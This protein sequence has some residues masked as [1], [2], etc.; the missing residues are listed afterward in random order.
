MISS[1]IPWVTHD[2]IW[3][4]REPVDPGLRVQVE[5]R[6]LQWGEIIAVQPG[7]WDWEQDDV[8]ITVRLDSGEVVSTTATMCR[9][10]YKPTAAD[11]ADRMIFPLLLDGLENDI[12]VGTPMFFYDEEE[13]EYQQGRVVGRHLEKQ[14]I[15][16][17][18]DHYYTV[19]EFFIETGRYAGLY[20]EDATTYVYRITRKYAHLDE[21]LKVHGVW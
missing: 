6:Q 9:Y 2:F 21:R 12:P 19:I 1:F 13:D 5:D 20:W 10:Q 7:L 11:L 8:P 4:I 16:R 18:F 14:E 3:A 15:I 17:A